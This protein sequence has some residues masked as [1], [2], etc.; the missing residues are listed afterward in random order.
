M[1]SVPQLP[2]IFTHVQS[3]E[4]MVAAHGEE[5]G[6]FL[7]TFQDPLRKLSHGN[8]G[9]IFTPNPSPSPSPSPSP[10]RSPSPSPN[11]DPSPNQASS[12]RPCL[13]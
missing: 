5:G 7:F 12:S 9:I 2:H 4:Q 8:D 6:K 3:R 1:F 11:P 13:C 10:N